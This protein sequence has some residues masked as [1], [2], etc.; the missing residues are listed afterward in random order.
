MALADA[1]VGDGMTFCR[2]ENS[3][4]IKRYKHTGKTSTNVTYNHTYYC[5]DGSNEYVWKDQSGSVDNSRCPASSIIGHT[6]LDPVGK[7]SLREGTAYTPSPTPTIVS[8]KIPTPVPTSTP[9]STNTPVPIPT[10]TPSGQGQQKCTEEDYVPKGNHHLFISSTSIDPSVSFNELVRKCQHL[11]NISSLKLNYFPLVSYQT[12][13]AKQIFEMNANWIN[14]G[15]IYNHNVLIANSWTDLWS[16]QVLQHGIEFDENGV[17]SSNEYIFTGT[18]IFGGQTFNCENWTTT[19]S[20]AMVGR[21]NDTSMGWIQL[22]S[23]TCTTTA[24]IY[25]L[26]LDTACNK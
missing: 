16:G 3:T 10:P 12:F 2:V 4:G 5:S 25:C 22:T 7:Y 15:A 26:S 8:T 20:N 1:G 11:A 24:K 14:T 19:Q 21:S 23:L 17:S 9:I 6:V 18:Q 13:G